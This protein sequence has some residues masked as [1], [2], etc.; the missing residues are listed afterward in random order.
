MIALLAT[1]STPSNLLKAQTGGVCDVTCKLNIMLW[2]QVVDS[3]SKVIFI[4]IFD[5]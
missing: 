4:M 1:Y 2:S 3:Q 5:L